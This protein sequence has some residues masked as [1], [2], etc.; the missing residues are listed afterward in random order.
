MSGVNLG[1]ERADYMHHHAKG[2]LMN[3]RRSIGAVL[4]LSRLTNAVVV[5]MLLGEMELAN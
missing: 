1:E 4:P 3:M 5:W 2:I